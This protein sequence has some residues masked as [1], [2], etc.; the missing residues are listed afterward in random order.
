[1][2]S[3]QNCE[4]CYLPLRDFIPPPQYF[5]FSNH[6]IFQIDFALLS[7]PLYHTPITN[8]SDPLN[9]FISLG[10]LFLKVTQ[11][12]QQWFSEV[13]CLGV[14]YKSKHTF[15]WG[16]TGET[17]SKQGNSVHRGICVEGEY[18]GCGTFLYQCN[19]PDSAIW[20]CPLVVSDILSV[21][22]IATAFF[23]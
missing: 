16:V 17:P 10:G 14:F 20:C 6:S 12:C 19:T 4:W 9:T 2:I 5:L 23:V 8:I 22:S 15:E 13:P 3:K 7:F 21:L 18:K 1:M 11:R